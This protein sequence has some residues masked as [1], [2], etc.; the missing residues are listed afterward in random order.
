MNY[1]YIFGHAIE[2]SNRITAGMIVTTYPAVVTTVSL[3]TE[4]PHH[5]SLVRSDSIPGEN[6]RSDS[7]T[8]RK[9]VDS[10]RSGRGQFPPGG[11]ATIPSATRGD[12]HTNPRTLPESADRNHRLHIEGV[13]Q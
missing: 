10:H 13:E 4:F 7:Q 3:K 2:P 8:N 5:I 12:I 1:P 11:F 6:A 9:S